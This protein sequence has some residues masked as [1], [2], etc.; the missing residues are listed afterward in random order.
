VEAPDLTWYERA[1]TW[2]PVN[3]WTWM[4][5]LALWLAIGLAVLPGVLRWRRANWQQGLAALSFAFFFAVRL[6]DPKG[7]A[8]AHRMTAA[9]STSKR[10]SIER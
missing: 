7:L 4:A 5:G 10:D 3:A 1:S 6:Y 9:S 2:L 8:C